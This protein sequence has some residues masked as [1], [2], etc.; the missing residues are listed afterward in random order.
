MTTTTEKPY[1]IHT[2][3]QLS[4]SI[5]LRLPHSNSMRAINSTLT[6]QAF[7][8]K[9]IAV[10]RIEGI[11]FNLLCLSYSCIAFIFGDPIA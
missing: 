10:F 2:P 4:P 11:K 5:L 1:I 8:T 7:L 6:G 3:A 9:V